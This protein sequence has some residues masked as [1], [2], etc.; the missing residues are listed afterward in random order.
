MIISPGSMCILNA[1]CEVS[2]RIPSPRMAKG[3]Y[4]I[5]LPFPSLC[6]NLRLPFLTDPFTPP[7]HPALPLSSPLLFTYLIILLSLYTFSPLL[8][9]LYPSSSS[10]PLY[11]S[12]R[13]HHCV[14]LVDTAVWFRSRVDE[15]GALGCG[16]DLLSALI[17][18]GAAPSRL[19][20]PAWGGHI[21]LHHLR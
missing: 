15:E 16:V 9:S 14:A 4:S 7:I 13:S 18:V 20:G 6:L 8:S 2:I 19:T 5:I 1:N 12:L 10:S 3:V 17:P 11:P 21:L